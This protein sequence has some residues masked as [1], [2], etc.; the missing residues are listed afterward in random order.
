MWYS[1]ANEE[2]VDAE[3]LPD[4]STEAAWW[5]DNF[6]PS[7]VEGALLD[8]AP[9]APDG[10]G[11]MHSD[12]AQSDVHRNAAPIGS[13]LTIR[14]R[15]AGG[16]MPRQCSTFTFRSDG[17]MVA[18]CGGIAGFRLTLIDPDTLDALA[19]YDLGMRSSALKSLVTRDLSHTFSDSSG[20][21]YFVLD[22][23]NRVVVGDPRQRIKRLSAQQT[24]G[25]WAFVVEDEWDM[26]DHVP[27]D[28]L[29][30]TNWFPEE[31]GCD[32]ITT[33]IPWSDGRL[34]WTT[35]GGIVGTLEPETGTVQTLRLEGEEIQNALAADESAV[36]VLTDHAQYALASDAEGMPQI[37]WRYAYD[38]GSA[39][40]LG[41]I[42]QGSGTTPTLLG[43]DY[44][45]FTD[46]ADDRINLVVLRRDGVSE[47][48]DRLICQ[49]PIF[50]SGASAAENSMIGIGRSI[51]IENNAGYTN[52]VDHKDWGSIKGGIARIDVREDE[53]GCETVWESDLVVPSVVPK[54]SQP[55]GIAYFYSFDLDGEGVPRWYIAGLNWETGKL[56]QRIPTGPGAEWNNNWA[57]LTIGPD[58]SLYAGTARGM[59][60]VRAK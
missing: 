23:E 25:A 51:V 12:A 52:A 48:E 14:S 7:P 38:R 19:T 42:N 10:L 44:I 24:D 41:S 20:G 59:L 22:A 15:K 31:G 45:T 1:S 29:W 53:S 9:L 32:G 47:G 4:A 16:K 21:A 13:D 5:D 49:V 39:R 2:Q 37:R 36:F 60:Q 17:L 34:W 56:V 8:Y 6:A 54:L 40:K 18:M 33:V 50:P 55:T 27:S 28:C 3:P 26:R 11:T 46:N 43:E 57:S 30:F 35:R 58:G